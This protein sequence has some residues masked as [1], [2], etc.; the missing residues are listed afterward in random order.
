M[1]RTI[2]DDNE[3]GRAARSSEPRL[4]RHCHALARA[5]RVT[6]LPKHG[7]CRNVTS[8]ELQQLIM[9]R[10]TSLYE[11]LSSLGACGGRGCV[12]H[13]KAA[14]VHAAKGSSGRT[15][16]SGLAVAAACQSWC[17]GALPTKEKI[18]GCD[19]AG[20]S[21][22]TGGGASMDKNPLKEESEQAASSQCQKLVAARLLS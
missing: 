22:T 2:A 19:S 17:G 20:A 21:G 8:S 16:T 5:S 7:E 1:Q 18:D 12:A 15:E 14:E 4:T 13:A 3:G 6:Y 9:R 11:H 10:Q